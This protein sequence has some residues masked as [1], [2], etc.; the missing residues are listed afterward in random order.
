MRAQA[1]YDQIQTPPKTLISILG[2]NHYG[3]TNTNN[4]SGSIPDTSIPTIAQ[5]VSVETIARWSG[6]F[7]RASVLNDKAA[8]DYIY[9]TGDA[10][11]T[12]V[13]VISQGKPI[14]EPSSILGLLILSVFGGAVL[15]LNKWQ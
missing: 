15:R 13:S 5:D 6:L 9:S 12:N 1:T 8:F 10:L 11:D 3:I 14:S 7:L 4:P 2:A